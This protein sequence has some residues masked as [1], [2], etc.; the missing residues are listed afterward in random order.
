MKIIL[1]TSKV[2]LEGVLNNSQTALKIHEKLPLEAKANTWG[3][4]IYFEIPLSLKPEN[5]TLDVE[6]GDIAY[7]P[8]GDCLC[9]F[10][11]RTP[12][13]INH[14]PRPASKVNIVGKVVDDISILKN[15]K[16]GDKITV[17][18]KNA[19]NQNKEI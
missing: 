5:A 13:S 6:V 10:F 9:I 7:W 17:M 3:E 1:K 8:E 4:E 2:T 16:S 12:V 18:K 14:K 11:G 19:E 15:I